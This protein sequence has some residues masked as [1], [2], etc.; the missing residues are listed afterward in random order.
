MGR[1]S[2]Q[3]PA[4]RPS[5]QVPALPENIKDASCICRKHNVQILLIRRNSIYSYSSWQR[6]HMLQLRRVCFQRKLVFVSSDK[7]RFGCHFYWVE[8]RVFA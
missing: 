1:D 5:C 6:K 2:H 8:L 4:D 7:F 3:E